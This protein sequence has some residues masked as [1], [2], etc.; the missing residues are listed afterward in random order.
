M[1]MSEHSE[2]HLGGQPHL[3]HALSA[4]NDIADAGEE[5]GIW[6]HGA[7]ITWLAAFVTSAASQH[8]V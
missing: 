6:F 4:A 2:R 1:V 7:G 8:H 5:A 3:L